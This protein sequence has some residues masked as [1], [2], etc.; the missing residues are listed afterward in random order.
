MILLSYSFRLATNPCCSSSIVLQRLRGT[1]AITALKGVCTSPLYRSERND[2]THGVGG[3]AK[4]DQSH[5]R[6]QM[7]QLEHVKK[8]LEATTELMFHHRLDWTFYTRDVVLEDHIFNFRRCG[9]DQVMRHLGLISVGCSYL[10][11]TVHLEPLNILPVLE[12]GTV[13]LRWRV[14][15]LNW[16]QTLDWRNFRAQHRKQNFKWYDGYSIFYVDGNGL[17]FK[18]TIQKTMPDDSSKTAERTKKLADR[19]GVLPGAS[20]NFV[21]VD[22]QSERRESQN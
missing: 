22:K 20:P 16:F 13:R 10:L 1:T 21:P 18:F 17:V 7:F 4:E 12:D 19:L 6:P 9:L 11:P 2:T 5:E 15:Y 8:R 14:K 3:G